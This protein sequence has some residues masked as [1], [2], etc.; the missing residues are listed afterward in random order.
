M[1]HLTRRL[2]HQWKDFFK[3]VDVLPT[4]QASR[5]KRQQQKFA[6]YPT[7]KKGCFENLFAN[8][9][10]MKTNTIQNIRHFNNTTIP[11]VVQSMV[12]VLG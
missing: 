4:V 1:K 6:G 12:E 2:L 8:F 11:N 5:K 3:E 7:V 9:I 10:F